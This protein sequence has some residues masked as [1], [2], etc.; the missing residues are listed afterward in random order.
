MKFIIFS[1][2]LLFLSSPIKSLRTKG[3]AIANK[4]GMMT[5]LNSFFSD[6]GTLPK[7]EE[8][9]R[10]S[11]VP[12]RRE[13]NTTI[14]QNKTLEGWF[15][16]QSSIYTNKITFPEISISQNEKYKIPLDFDNWRI[17]TD[18]QSKKENDNK[19]FYFY[20]S[21]LNIYYSYSK[22]SLNILDAFSLTMIQSL[23]R[24][25]GPVYNNKE[26]HCI[27]ISGYNSIVWKICNERED[28]I[29]EWFCT[30]KLSLQMKDSFCEKKNDDSPKKVIEKTVNQP[31]IIIPLPSPQCNDHWNYFKHGSD[32]ECT[33]KEGKQ[34]SPIDLPYKEGAV[35]TTVK[36]F[37]NFVT[38]DPPQSYDTSDPAAQMN[39]I[40]QDNMIKIFHKNFGTAATLD[41]AV[42]RAQEITFHTPGEH[43]IQGK[44]FEMEMQVIFYGESVGDIAK[45]LILSFPIQKTPGAQNKFFNDLPFDDLPSNEYKR[46][47][48]RNKLYIPKIFYND[49]DLDAITMKPFSFYTYEGSLPFPPCSENTIVYVAAEPIPLSSTVIELFKEAIRP[50][51]SQCENEENYEESF[52][53]YENNR[54]TQPLNGRPVFYYD[55][56]K[57]CGFVEEKKKKSKEKG[58]Y[59]KFLKSQTEY[60]YVDGQAPSGLP[61]SLVVSKAEAKRLKQ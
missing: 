29:K 24:E 55:H 40:L 13:D 21:G 46:K 38:V 52:K 60:F 20:L 10:F 1:L 44:V 57:A 6:M 42:Y 36:P 16:I 49:K 51:M 33:C 25:S 7:K 37:F 23:G 27:L 26:T 22:D 61:G 28:V 14:A 18:V 5:Y 8:P 56:Y 53:L 43:T 50:R 39:M 2:F 35:H 9:H 48:I 58:H 15:M 47:P 54:E 11:Q 30:I 4:E 41:G 3:K 59:E 31:I 45:Q 17:N 12:D 34:Q 32:W 19:F